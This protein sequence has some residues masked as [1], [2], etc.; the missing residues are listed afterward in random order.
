LGITGA[1]FYPWR[2]KWRAVLWWVV[3]RQTLRA[4]MNALSPHMFS[5][6]KLHSDDT[7]IWVLGGSTARDV[8]KSVA[9]QEWVPEY[10]HGR[11]FPILKV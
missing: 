11:L 8:A 4:L 10:V 9:Q 5:V 2:S 6:A 7:P 1:L 3:P